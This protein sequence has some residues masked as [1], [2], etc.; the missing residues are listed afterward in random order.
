MTVSAGEGGRRCKVSVTEPIKICSSRTTDP[1]TSLCLTTSPWLWADV[2][3]PPGKHSQVTLL[4]VHI[5]YVC[6]F[7]WISPFVR[8]NLGFRPARWGH[9]VMRTCAWDYF[10]L[11]S[12]HRML[13][14]KSECF[15][16]DLICPIQINCLRCETFNPF[17]ETFLSANVPVC[18]LYET[19]C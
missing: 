7:S 1:N 16:S 17:W 10:D 13:C 12:K 8:T 18:L 14:A 2:R 11:F 19:L 15:I 4:C 5:L 9:F 3:T 6:V